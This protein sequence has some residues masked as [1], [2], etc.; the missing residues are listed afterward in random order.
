MTIDFKIIDEEKIDGVKLIFPSIAS[1]DRGNI[2]T[3]Y[4]KND[5]KKLLPD[6]QEFKHDKFSQSK[7]NVLRGIH[8]D[9]KS[10]KLVTCVYGEI[11]QVVVDLR[12]NS[13]TYQSWISFDIS[14]KN[15]KLVLIPPGCG[16][17]YYVKSD[18]AVYHYKLAYSGEYID[19][20]E[21]FT[22]PWNDSRLNINWPSK[23]PIL[24]NRDAGVQNAKN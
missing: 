18:N 20:E 15:Q 3:S 4:L 17:A 23:E 12:D 11:F 13:P 22:Y 5:L 8:G 19:Y 21:Q 9:H 24:S 10:W 2:W 14:D 1:D 6:N 7:K 16:N